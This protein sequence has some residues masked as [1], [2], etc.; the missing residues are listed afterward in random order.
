MTINP[1][2]LRLDRFASMDARTHRR[3]VDRQHGYLGRPYVHH[4]APG[5]HV[6]P[7]KIELTEQHNLNLRMERK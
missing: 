6:W 7:I 2:I 5:D 4:R 3:G 1:S